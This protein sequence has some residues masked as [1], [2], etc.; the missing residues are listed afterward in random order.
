MSAV[1]VNPADV[2][3]ADPVSRC[4]TICATPAR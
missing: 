3:A 2:S 1:T 4:A